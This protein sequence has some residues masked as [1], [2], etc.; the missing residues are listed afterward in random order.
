MS[1]TW[2]TAGELS[3][4]PSKSNIFFARKCLLSQHPSKSWGNECFFYISTLY[5]HLSGI[6]LLE[7]TLPWIPR[8]LIWSKR[9]DLSS[10]LCCSSPSPIK[11]LVTVLQASFLH[12]WFYAKP[13]NM[14]FFFLNGTVLAGFI[15]QSLLFP[16][17]NFFEKIY[18]YV[19]F[20]KFRCGLLFAGALVLWPLKMGIADHYS[21]FYWSVI[22]VSFLFR[23]WCLNFPFLDNFSLA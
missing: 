7:L 21:W 1:L 15:H 20:T 9:T 5:N 17:F 23:F 3:V 12:V 16:T 13:L 8:K 10:F 11:S 19:F 4:Y 22:S 14:R 6:L 2:A 18:I